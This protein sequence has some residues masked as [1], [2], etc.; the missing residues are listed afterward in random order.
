[1]NASQPLYEL[2]YSLYGSSAAWL[3]LIITTIFIAATISLPC[4]ETW[5]VHFEW[6]CTNLHFCWYSMDVYRHITRHQEM[7]GAA[8]HHAAGLTPTLRTGT[9]MDNFCPFT[10]LAFLY[11]A[12]PQLLSLHLPSPLSCTTATNH[13]LK[14]NREPWIWGKLKLIEG[15]GYMHMLAISTAE[16]L[17]VQHISCGVWI[18]L[19]G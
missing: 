10:Q 4:H 12:H 6:Q 19:P 3:I 11:V 15:G 7:D 16:M 8:T 5:L 13:C 9:R 1:M 17:K 2:W 18:Y 14:I